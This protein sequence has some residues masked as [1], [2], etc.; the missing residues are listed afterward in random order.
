MV[1]V[2][3]L[4]YGYLS[5]AVPCGLALCGREGL[6]WSYYVVS[7]FGMNKCPSSVGGKRRKH[8]VEIFTSRV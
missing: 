1:E 5:I 3:D 2:K 4:F 6:N 8:T 7:L